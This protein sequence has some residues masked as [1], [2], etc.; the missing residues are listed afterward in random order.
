MTYGLIDKI[1]VPDMFRINFFLLPSGAYNTNF[2]S[3]FHIM[4]TVML[5]ADK[6]QSVNKKALSSSQQNYLR[7]LTVV[8]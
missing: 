7:Y 4:G 2:K 5:S 8:P 6:E 3:N 1:L